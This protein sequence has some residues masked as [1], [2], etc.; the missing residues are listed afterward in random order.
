[1]IGAKEIPQWNDLCL[2]FGESKASPRPLGITHYSG[3]RNR[4]GAALDERRAAVLPDLLDHTLRHL[5]YLILG[6]VSSEEYFFDRPV[7]VIASSD[8]LDSTKGIGSC[9]AQT[10]SSPMAADQPAY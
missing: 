5:I 9:L 3:S 6:A 10:H 8:A 7:L 4:S 2:P 1:M